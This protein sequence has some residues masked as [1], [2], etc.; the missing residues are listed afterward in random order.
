MSCEISTINWLFRVTKWAD[1][2]G[3]TKSKEDSE[4]FEKYW[5]SEIVL[6]YSG[7]LDSTT[8]LYDLLDRGYKVVAMSVNYGQKHSQELEQAKMICD[9]L[10]VEQIMLDLSNVSI[11]QTNWLVNKELEIKDGLYDKE[12]IEST[13]VLNRNSILANYAIAYA[14]N[15]KA[16]GIALGIHSEDESTGEIEYPDCSPS[17]VKAL[18]ELA[19]EV[20]F[21]PYEVMVPFSGKH[22]GDVVKRGLELKVPYDLTWSCYKWQSN[23]KACGT[24]GTCIQRLNAF[25]SN[26]AVDPIEYEV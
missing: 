14:M 22:K 6:V 4:L 1:V 16:I 25:K 19:K 2:I 13:M 8:V 11:F 21:R 17:F 5:T 7:G 9:K 10:G 26:N 3:M 15:R 23:G 18:Q 12:V 20:D 24:C